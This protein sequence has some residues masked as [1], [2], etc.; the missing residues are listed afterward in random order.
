M[1]AETFMVSMKICQNL[2]VFLNQRLFD[3]W[4]V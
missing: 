3:F 1:L 2:P 4:H